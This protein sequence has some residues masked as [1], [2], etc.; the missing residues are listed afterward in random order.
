MAPATITEAV[1]LRSFAFG[2]ADRVLHVYTQVSGRLGVVAKGVRRTKS[3]FGGRLEPFSHVELSIHRGRGELGTVT[4]ASLVRSHDAIRTDP[5]RLRAGLV[6]LE[7]M[8]RLYTEE[9]RSDRAF[10]ALT[11][12]LEALD[13]RDAQPGRKPALDPLVLSF[14]LKLLWLSGFLPH[15]GSCVEC[16]AEEGLVAFLPSAG[17]AVCAACDP[18][19]IELSPEGLRGIAGLL[20]SPIADAPAVGLGD[21]AAREVL[22]VVTSSYEHHG[23]FR[24]RTPRRSGTLALRASAPG[25]GRRAPMAGTFA[26]SADVPDAGSC[27]GEAD[28]EGGGL[29]GCAPPAGRGSERRIPQQRNPACEQTSETFEHVLERALGDQLVGELVAAGPDLAAHDAVLGEAVLADPVEARGVDVDRDRGLAELVA[30]AM[31][32]SRASLARV[33]RAKVELDVVAAVDEQVLPN[34]ARGAAERDTRDVVVV[35]PRSLAGHPRQ[36]PCVDVL[37]LVEELVSALIRIHTDERLPDVRALEDVDRQLLEL[38][39]REKAIVRDEIAQR[40]ERRREEGFR[41]LPR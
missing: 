27:G 10:L 8:L 23:G 26:R 6:G 38:V 1:V 9:E 36:H 39:G 16:G 18:G 21:R 29:Q 30:D 14:Q 24:L 41:H 13:E 4:G 3:R 31:D 25:P 20:G 28:T 22:A 19:G 33:T 34:A 32:V 37:V 7:A 40:R 15:L 12:F 35:E 5:Y 11:R 17:G 2:E